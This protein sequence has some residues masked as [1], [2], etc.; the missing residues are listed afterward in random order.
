MLPQKKSKE[1]LIIL[2]YCRMTATAPIFPEGAFEF[3]L[4][5][6]LSLAEAG[7][8]VEDKRTGEFE[9]MFGC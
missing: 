2:L 9:I 4:P 8:T 6:A 7:T 5:H 3:A 1:A